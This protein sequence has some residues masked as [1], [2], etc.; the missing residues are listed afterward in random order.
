MNAAIRAA[1]YLL[2]GKT[3]LARWRAGAF[4]EIEDALLL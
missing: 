1:T 4:D 3:S 2:Q